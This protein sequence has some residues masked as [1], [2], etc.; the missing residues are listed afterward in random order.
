MRE[1]EAASFVV[2]GPALIDIRASM[3]VCGL[4]ILLFTLPTFIALRDR[5]RPPAPR[6]GV[7]E[8]YRLLADSVLPNW[9][10]R[11]GQNC[12]GSWNLF[13]APELGITAKAPR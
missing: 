12:A 3:I 2:I 11:C 8:S 5:P 10:Q 6:V 9:V 13:M 4:W 7:V 1:R